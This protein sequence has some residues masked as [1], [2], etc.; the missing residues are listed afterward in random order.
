[1]KYFVILVIGLIGLG[2]FLRFNNDV[3]LNETTEINEVEEKQ[4]IR[5]RNIKK[6]AQQNLN[7]PDPSF[8]PPNPANPPIDYTP[9][10]S[11]YHTGN[12][13]YQDSC[14][15]TDADGNCSFEPVNEI[16]EESR[17]DD[18][19]LTMDSAR[20]VDEFRRAEENEYNKYLNEE[21]FESFRTPASDE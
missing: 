2:V 20:N 11:F 21:T 12:E 7:Q 9:T 1:M 19:N 4:I 10:S 17:H 3:S 5:S 13:E 16:A 15:F 8:A 18:E 6:A 14:P